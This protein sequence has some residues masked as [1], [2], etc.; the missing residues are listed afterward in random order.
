MQV[1][2]CRRIV[3]LMDIDNY[4]VTLLNELKEVDIGGSK[5]LD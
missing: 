5:S 1:Q 4:M 2:F 3:W